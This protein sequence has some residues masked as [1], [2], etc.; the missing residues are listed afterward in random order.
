MI[1]LQRIHKL[2]GDTL[3]LG[4]SIT[5]RLVPSAQTAVLGVPSCS[6]TAGIKLLDGTIQFPKNTTY[7]LEINNLF[8]GEYEPVLKDTEEWDFKRFRDSSL[9]SIAAKPT[10]MLLS[11]VYYLQ[12]GNG[13]HDG[14]LSLD[15]PRLHPENIEAAGMPTPEEL[16]S[17]KAIING[18]EKIRSM[19]GRICLARFPTRDPHDFDR[20][21]T[22][23]CKLANHLNL[24]V[25]NYN[26][27]EWKKRLD[28]SD[29]RHLNSR[30]PSTSKFREA[31]R[32][33]AKACAK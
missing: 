24:P 19:G 25:L 29:S 2:Q 11:L 32:R 21:Y 7:V 27:D 33:D 9:L 13:L 23:A 26:I 14:K 31:I 12:K 8:N 10:N 17:W 16:E 18:I 5:E 30:A 6:F 3:I 22:D 20:A 1:R 28:F 4:S 15:T